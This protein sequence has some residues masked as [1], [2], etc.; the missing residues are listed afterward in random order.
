[1]TLREALS[2]T[3]VFDA[4]FWLQTMKILGYPLRDEA[5]DIS[6]LKGQK[7]I[8]ADLTPKSISRIYFSDFVEIVLIDL[9]PENTITRAACTRIARGWKSNRLTKPLLLFAGTKD[10][11]AVIVPGKGTGGE[12]KILGISDRLFRTDLD[13]LESIEYPGSSEDLNIRYD[14]TFFPYEK[15]RTEFFEGYKDLYQRTENAVRKYLKDASSSYSQRFL[16]R[17]MFLYFLQKKGWLKNDKSFIATIQDYKA[18]NA[19]FYKSLNREGTPGIPFLNGSLFE[20]EDYMNAEMEERLYRDMDSLF[21]DARQFFNDYN[22]TVD[23]LEPLEFDVSIDPA[24]IGTVFENML[25]EHE[26]GSK[27][28]FYTPRSESSFICRRAIANFL[29]LTDDV[30]SDGKIF[31]DGLSEYVAKLKAS[32]SE[33]EI[34]SFKEKLLSLKILDPA[35]GSGGF[36]LVAMQEI[37]GLIGEAESIVGWH[38]DVEDHKKRILPNLY[39]FDVEPE[40]IEIARLRLWLSLIID[41][42]EPEPLPN[43]DLN[44]VVIR[45][46]LSL[47]SPQ[48]SLDPEIEN[49]RESFEEIR[50]RYLNEHDSRHKMRLKEQLQHISA[51]ISKRANTEPNVIEAYMPS[52]ANIVVMNPPYV[53][54]L[55]ISDKKKQ[56]Y[57]SAYGLDKKS[58]LYAYFLLRALRLVSDDGSVSVISSDKWLETGYGISLQRKLKQNLVAVYGQRERSF[59]ADINTVITVYSKQ[60]PSEEVRFAYLESYAKAEVTRSVVIQRQLL[61]PGSW[62]YLRAPRMFVERILPKLVHTLT[63]FAEVA[64][65][66]TTGANEFFYLKDVGHLYEPDRLADP[67]QFERLGINASSAK[68][69]EK[70]GLVYAEN[71]TGKRFVINKKDVFPAIRSPTEIT[72]YLVKNLH[73]LAFSP[74]PPAKPGK[75][76]QRYIAWAENCPVLVT[77]GKDKGKKLRGYNKLATVNAHRPYWHT[78]SDLNPGD[79]FHPIGTDKRHFVARTLTPCLADQMLVMCKV[80]R[81]VDA[82]SLWLFLNSTISFLLFELYGR[83]FGGGA[84]QFPTGTM[85]SLLVPNIVDLHYPPD[86]GKYLER[87]ILTYDLELQ[88]EERKKLDA[89]TLSALGI[90]DDSLVSQMHD[91]LRDLIEDR[92]IKSGRELTEISVEA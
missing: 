36:L 68:E 23:E 79:L 43:L 60:P 70:L 29:K 25:P 21:K 73:T 74:D 19:L 53:G 13:V 61:V 84:L 17:L 85:D 77:R 6:T 9:G 65:G 67:K 72:N 90:E 64:R 47:P 35:V 24:L 92:L 76:S 63:E 33:R 28:T 14:T 69:L 44:L 62:F 83:R 32:K 45:D 81:G 54:Q 22:F 10:S 75:Y 16:G 82:T 78:L 91:A 20:K 3:T 18:L 51:D 40:A 46:S 88:R 34:R 37:I 58:D 42:R 49:L 87:E 7:A 5:L 38:S 1:L 50:A 4:S 26:R 39:G 56:Y 57:S 30:S 66:F 89:V 41:Q 52:A 15:V 11:F 59:N 8:P 80:R 55:S 31:R 48:R 12:A 71:E 86:A 27:G 2:T